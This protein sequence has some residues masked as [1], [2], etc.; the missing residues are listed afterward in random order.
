[1]SIWKW[2][3]QEQGNRSTAT[4]GDRELVEILSGPDSAHRRELETMIEDQ[5]R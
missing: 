4:R 1:M 5:R 2:K 3:K